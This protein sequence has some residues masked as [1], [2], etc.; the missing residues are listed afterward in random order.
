MRP[1]TGFT[2]KAWIEEHKP[3]YFLVSGE[4]H[5]L[6]IFTKAKDVLDKARPGLRVLCRLGTRHDA[7]RR[8][9]WPPL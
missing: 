6:G 2:E 9:V 5:E 4:G 3:F 8:Q 7:E 1:P